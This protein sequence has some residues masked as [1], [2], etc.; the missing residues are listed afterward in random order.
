LDEWHWLVAA[1]GIA[2]S[3]AS[4]AGFSSAA[5]FSASALLLLSFLPLASSCAFAF[6][7]GTFPAA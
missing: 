2:V 4:S 3:G 5:P 7:A 1:P 6:P